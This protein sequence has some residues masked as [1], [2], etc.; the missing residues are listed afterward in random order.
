MG[1]Q[2]CV[3]RYDTIGREGNGNFGMLLLLLRRDRHLSLDFASKEQVLLLL[4]PIVKG[5]V[6]LENIFHQF[7]FLG[8]RHIR[9]YILVYGYLLLDVIKRFLE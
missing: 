1:V 6:S 9:D 2:Y 3:H 7:L 4:P 5:F 8:F